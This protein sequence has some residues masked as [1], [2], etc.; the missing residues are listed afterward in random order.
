M[1]RTEMERLRKKGYVPYRW[2][3]RWAA[4]DPFL[5]YDTLREWGVRT[6]TFAEVSDGDGVVYVF[7]MRHAPR[8]IARRFWEAV[9]ERVRV[10]GLARGFIR[11]ARAWLGEPV[12]GEA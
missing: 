2:T 11:A 12:W 8:A 1:T 7:A 4:E 3:W 10:H 6:R 5:P 9:D